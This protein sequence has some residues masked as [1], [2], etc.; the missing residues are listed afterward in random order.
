MCC[1]VILTVTEFYLLDGNS[2]RASDDVHL[3]HYTEVLYHPCLC[4]L[5]WQLPHA[6]AMGGCGPGLLGAQHRCFLWEVFQ[7]KMSR[8]L[9]CIVLYY[10]HAMLHALIAAD[11]AI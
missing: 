3:H 10:Y 6:T 8:I 4:P 1:I 11:D 5:L 2:L 9:D 7:T